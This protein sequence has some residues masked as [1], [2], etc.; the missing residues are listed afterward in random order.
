MDQKDYYKILML[1]PGAEKFLI[2]TVFKR[3]AREY[4]PDVSNKRDAHERM[5]D[6]NEAHDVLSD[7]TRRKA[8]DE[9]YKRELATKVETAQRT[10]AYSTSERPN[11]QPDSTV[12]QAKATDTV[13]TLPFPPNPA[14]FGISVGYLEHAF[15]GAYEWEKRKHR[16]SKN[17]KIVIRIVC[18]IG[19]VAISL[20]C[21]SQ[22]DDGL[23]HIAWFAWFT[24]PLICE[25]MLAVIE[26]IHDN[27]LRRTEFNPRYDPNPIGYNRY[28]T[29]HAKYESEIIDVYVSRNW[30]YH[31]NKYCCNMSNYSTMPKWVATKKNAVPCAHCGHFSVPPQILPPPFGNGYLP[32]H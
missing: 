24:S 18:I 16:I 1:H 3:L 14:N 10:T 8:Y 9:V 12:K 20:V 19:G 29:E 7:P 17:I 31:S 15:E 13:S 22:S 4:H 21:A 25:I 23:K 5:S 32:K 11:P 27:Q 6:I 2:D 30:K 26:S 28:A